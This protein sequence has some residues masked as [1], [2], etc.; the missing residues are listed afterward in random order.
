MLFSSDAL[1][2]NKLLF[3]FSLFKFNILLHINYAADVFP[4]PLFPKNII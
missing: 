3:Y 1:I 2:I 4:E